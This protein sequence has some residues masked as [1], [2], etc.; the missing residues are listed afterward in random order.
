MYK[1]LESE[2][3]ISGGSLVR[4]QH[5][6]FIIMFGNVSKLSSFN[7]CCVELIMLIFEQLDF[8]ELQ[9]SFSNLNSYLNNIINDK[10][11]HIAINLAS[12]ES[13]TKFQ[14]Y[15]NNLSTNILEQRLASVILTSNY[16]S[17]FLVDTYYHQLFRSIQSLKLMDM[18]FEHLKSILFKLKLT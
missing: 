9:L 3:G 13:P 5:C 1:S 14:Y 18:N 11:L 15:F 4:P 6:K 2:V 8:Y 7:D 10:R 16:S 17:L 12:Y